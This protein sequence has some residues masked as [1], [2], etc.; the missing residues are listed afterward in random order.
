M[1]AAA[2]RA[3]M[4]ALRVRGFLNPRKDGS[5]PGMSELE[6]DPAGAD[7]VVQPPNPVNS[8][9]A[10]AR[11]M[12]WLSLPLI[13]AQLA[14][15]GISTTDVVMM[16]WL[17]PA[18]LAGGAL[19]QN[20]MFP[21]Y[22]FGLGVVTAV[23]P[24]AS[25]SVGAGD[26]RGARRSVRQGLWVGLVIGVPATAL[27]WQSE[28]ILLQLGQAPETAA[29]AQSYLRPAAFSLIPWFWIVALRCFVT[30]LSRPRVVLVATLL[31]V[32]LN[33]LG[34]YALMFGNFG[35]PRLELAGAGLSSA[36]VNLFMFLLLAGYILWDRE[37]KRYDL[38]VRFW[39]SDWPRFWELWRV[40]L[41]IGLTILAESLLFASAGLLVGL[42]STDALA[43]HA[44]ALQCVAVAF[45]VPLGISQATTARVGL[46]IGAGDLPAVGRA[47]W[48][49]LALGIFLMAGFALAFW[50]YGEV[51][52]DLF[53]DL[54]LAENQP[55][56]P[57]A[58][59]FIAVAALFQFFDGGQVV[60]AGALR[61]MK[62]TR[63]PMWI[64]VFG[65]WGVG[66]PVSLLL[67]FELGYGGEGVWMGL[68]VG[69]GV[70]FFLQIWR[71]RR[72]GRFLARYPA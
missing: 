41:P 72:R 19:G 15:I 47:G 70:V 8:W 12:L 42:I 48:A 61:G 49:A 33:A 22:L 50:S 71:F 51:L 2:A 11:A 68:V 60:L 3:R 63:V 58:V 66:F 20:M 27:L 35:F 59:S 28:A 34:N 54:D 39:R 25:Q 26:H 52:V 40:G 36:L 18:Q 65:Y 31:G 67:G 32:A 5:L 45:M 29:L 62:D 30:A 17:G 43:A 53:L 64:A 24:L 9:G 55:V 37:F 7:A 46:V 16:G 6:T 44:I 1:G 13:L 21:V 10:E 23:A 57:L 38:F 4:A 69:L 56:L 14:S